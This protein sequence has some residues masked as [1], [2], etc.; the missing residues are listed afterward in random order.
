MRMGG[1]THENHVKL[2]PSLLVGVQSF[3]AVH[4]GCV[5]EVK[6]SHIGNEKF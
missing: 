6:L 2:A 1:K 4:G 3:K 5:I